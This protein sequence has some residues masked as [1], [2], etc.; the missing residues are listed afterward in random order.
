[1]SAWPTT[2]LELTER[3]TGTARATH[4]VTLSF[5]HRQRSRLRTGLDGGGEAAIVLPRGQVLR[6]GDRLRSRCGVVVAVRAAPEALS[7]VEAPDAG[8]LARAAYHLGN[9]HVPVQVGP[10]WLRY[11]HDHVLDGMIRALGLAV[12][13]CRAPFEPEA[14]A[15]A[16]HHHGPGHAHEHEHG[17]GES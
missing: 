13:A 12:S 10:G 16:G 9:R 17:D 14:G 15:Y 11:A 5:E 3:D 4:S 2:L 7:H 6:G 1:M 8:A